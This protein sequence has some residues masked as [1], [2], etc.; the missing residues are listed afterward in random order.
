MYEWYIEFEEDYEYPQPPQVLQARLIQ[1]D[2]EYDSYWSY[3]VYA[4]TL[5]EALEKAYVE[6]ADM[7][8]MEAGI[9]NTLLTSEADYDMY[10]EEDEEDE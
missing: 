1:D 2:D 4:N 10:E 3:S 9:P 5:E 7:C 8:E 6:Y